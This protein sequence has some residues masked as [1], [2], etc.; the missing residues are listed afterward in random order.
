MPP[1]ITWFSTSRASRS[2]S[3]RVSPGKP[4][5]RWA[6]SIDRFNTA[7]GR[8]GNVGLLR[9]TTEVARAGPKCAS[10]SATTCSWS[11]SP[12]AATTN[13]DGP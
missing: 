9:G 10:T 8:L 12:A 4:I 7:S 1:P 6:C 3:V 5:A 11:I 13:A 2:G